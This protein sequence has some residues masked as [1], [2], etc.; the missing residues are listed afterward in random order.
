MLTTIIYVILAVLALAGLGLG[1]SLARGIRRRQSKLLLEQCRLAFMKN[2]ESLEQQFAVGGF[3][4]DAC[5]RCAVEDV[6]GRAGT[7][8]GKEDV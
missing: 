1:V 7:G 8:D 2:R 5:C 3:K 4:F 6:L